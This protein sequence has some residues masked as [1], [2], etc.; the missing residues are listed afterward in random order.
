MTKSET[1]TWHN[2]LVHVYIIHIMLFECNYIFYR[3]YILQ[4]ENKKGDKQ[5]DNSDESTNVLDEKV[6]I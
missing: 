2:N 5:E 6:C 1:D 4:R 3:Y